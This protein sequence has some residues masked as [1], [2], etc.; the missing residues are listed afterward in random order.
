MGVRL[1]RGVV[2]HYAWG[3]PSALP[4]LIG[5]E[6]D[7]RPWA[8][9][10]FGT[11]PGGPAT[12]VE[13]GQ[14][15]RPLADIAGA[16]PYLLKLLAAG[17]PLSLQAHPTAEQ[18]EIGFTREQS[19]GIPLTS[20]H[21]TYRDPFPKPELLVALTP[22]EALCG[23]RPVERT[24]RLLAGIG[25]PA[26]ELSR[27][28]ESHGLAGALRWLL[29]DGAPLDPIVAECRHRDGDAARWT[30]ALAELHPDDPAA[31]APLLLNHVELRPGEALYLGPG[32]LHAYL[33]GTGVEAMGSSDN[34][35]R[36]GLT[37]KHVDVHE[38][39][40]IV[41]PSPV[42]DPV[43]RPRRVTEGLWRYDTPGA[44]FTVYSQHVR[45]EAVVHA[46]GRELVLCALGHT[47]ALA[48]GEVAFLRPGEELGLRGVATL[49]RVSDA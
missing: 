32:N 36:G 16:L 30:V 27:R 47:D 28:I 9:L 37:S 6:P 7:G 34:V 20:P 1:V 15:D 22:F 38:L 25:R 45:D 4:E 42:A 24:L 13:P 49:F 18:A 39:L 23:F 43:V 3:H 44:P 8:E 40:E 33:H 12:V 31:L 35:V 2:Q 29:E 46:R 19:A 14:P 21:R 48:R 17:A 26:A 5:A 41:D 10:W 11:H